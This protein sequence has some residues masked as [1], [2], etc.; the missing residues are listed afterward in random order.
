MVLLEDVFGDGGAFPEIHTTQ[1]PLKMGQKSSS[2][3]L[4]RHALVPAL[5]SEAT[6][7]ELKRPSEEETDE[8]VQQ[9]AA[10][11]A[12]DNNKAVQ[13]QMVNQK[14]TYVRY[15]PKQAGPDGARIIRL[16]EAPVDPLEPPKFKH[17]R[18][19]RG[20]PS[21]PAP[22][23]HSPPRKLTPG[24]MAAWKIPPCISNWK[25]PKG[26][27]IPL[28]KRLAADGRGL[29]ETTVNDN[30]AKLSE[31]LYIAERSARDEVES[32]MKM[33]KHLASKQKQK[34][35]EELRK[36]AIQ[37]KEERARAGPRDDA[38]PA[39]DEETRRNERYELKRELQREKRLE[40]QKGKRD[41]ERDVGEKIALGQAAQSRSSES[42][43]DSRLFNQNSGIGGGFGHDED[44]NVYDNALFRGSSGANY[45]PDKDRIAAERDRMGKTEKF[46]Q[47]LEFEKDQE[48]DPFGLGQILTEA[49]GTK[50]GLDD[51]D[52]D[53]KRQR[54]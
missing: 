42:F 50:R 18:V 31:A 37:A 19:P 1:Y 16:V 21:P 25:N 29:Q 3:T 49:K 43:Y 30:F 36:L 53:R 48:D 20:P 22:V 39:Q 40:A 9:T 24:D 4:T 12:A 15:T 8:L 47:S 2:H 32:R 44:Y 14:P 13:Q 52:L 6:Q 7:D 23:N 54:V 45:R 33:A 51:L 11:L 41:R 34:K 28:D 5:S 35:E 38:T 26:Y 17:K 10:L 27:T 46:S